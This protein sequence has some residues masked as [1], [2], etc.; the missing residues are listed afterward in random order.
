[1]MALFS[2]APSPLRGRVRVRTLVYTRWIAVVGQ[3]GTVLVINFGM[4]I[5]LPLVPIL[6]G[7]ACSA[8]LNIQVTVHR[9]LNGWHSDRGAAAFLGYDILQLSW[10]LYLTGGLTNPFSLMFLVPATISAT[11][12]S[13]RSTIGLGL[14]TFASVSFLSFHHM[15]LPWADGNLILPFRYLL[16]IWVSINFGVAFL[17]FYA[18]RVAEE[19]RIMSD[20]LTETQFALSREREISSLGALAAATAHELGT[21]LGTIALVTKELAR[22]FP[23]DSE[24][25]KEFVLLT[26]QVNRCREM[27]AQLTKNPHQHLDA[28]NSQ[29]SIDTL[30]SFIADRHPK[31]GIEITIANR[32]DGQP[33]LVTKTAELVHGIGNFIDNA[34]EF[35]STRVEIEIEWDEQEIRLTIMDDGPGFPAGIVDLLGEPYISTRSK[36]G[37]MGLGVFVSKTLLER[38]GANM[39]FFNRGSDRGAVVAITWSRHVIGARCTDAK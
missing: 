20:A 4:D 24:H 14:V 27:L 33:P 39:R 36:T 37:R 22:E 31:D 5:N 12:L 15:A 7:V 34:T 18:W 26:D 32:G 35:A 28:T 23:E 8:V 25:G 11:I 9:G 6:L 19:S 17:I 30:A 21:P 13:L 3:L 10:M 38:T 29:M 2:A 1:M 16:G